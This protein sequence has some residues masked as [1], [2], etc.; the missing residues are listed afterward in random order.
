MDW[1]VVCVLV[2][3]ATLIF[4]AC[5]SL[6]VKAVLAYYRNLETFRKQ[7]GFRRPQPRCDLSP[8]NVCKQTLRAVE[9]IVWLVM[10]RLLRRCLLRMMVGGPRLWLL[11]L[12]R[13]VFFPC[14]VLHLVVAI[15]VVA[16]VEDKAL[17]LHRPPIFWTAIFFGVAALV[18]G[19]LYAVIRKPRTQLQTR[20]F[21][22]LCCAALV[23]DIVFTVTV[24]AALRPLAQLHCLEPRNK[25]IFAF[26]HSIR[27]GY[28]H[29]GVQDACLRDST[30]DC[31]ASGPGYLS[32]RFVTC[33]LCNTPPADVV[34]TLA[35]AGLFAGHPSARPVLNTTANGTAGVCS[36]A[37]GQLAPGSELNCVPPSTHALNMTDGDMRDVGMN[38]TA[39]ALPCESVQSCISCMAAKTVPRFFFAHAAILVVALVA[40]HEH[41]MH[42]QEDAPETLKERTQRLESEMMARKA[43]MSGRKLAPIKVQPTRKLAWD[44]GK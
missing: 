31:A 19:V 16:L 43:I 15:L 18:D 30:C 37:F 22:K 27:L 12:S 42:L 11:L 1:V 13:L 29:L 9:F 36:F 2:G 38:E 23:T 21:A 4:A 10:E 20:L 33:L 28:V 3:F 8:H 24:D 34:R 41:G 26:Y 17:H 39:A 35:A 5:C 6:G 40:A 7:F 32:P 14:F 25:P 44:T